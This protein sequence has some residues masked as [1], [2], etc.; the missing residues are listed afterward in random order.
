MAE[1][2]DVQQQTSKFGIALLEF[3]NK[4]TQAKH[5]VALP[6]KS[7]NGN[8]ARTEIVQNRPQAD[9]QTEMRAGFENITHPKICVSKWREELI[10]LEE[11]LYCIDGYMEKAKSLN[12]T[13]YN[14]GED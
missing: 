8:A 1:I 10:T 2:V 6:V 11:A 4:T 7:N 14:G 5:V 3:G 13:L 12:S 9:N